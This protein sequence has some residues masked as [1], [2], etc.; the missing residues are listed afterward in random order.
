MKLSIIIPVYNEEQTIKE[1]ID[2]VRKVDLGEIEKEIVIVDDGSSDKSGQIIMSEIEEVDRGT[3]KTHLS[4]INLGKGAA[5]R[6]GM[7]I[8]TGD[9]FLI[10]DADLELDPNEYGKLL[11]PIVAG[12]TNVVY[13]SRFL[14]GKN[15]VPL[16]TWIANRF[17]TLLTNMLYGGKLTDMETSYKVLRREVVEGLRLRSVE[18]D[19]EPEITA[20]ILKKGEKIIELPI[21]YKPR[22]WDEGKK[23]GFKDGI[24]AIFTLFK[25]R[26]IR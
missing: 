12:H 19:F 10:Q 2:K 17:L 7:V 3:V 22:R 9:I 8:A 20:K 25:Y 26:F 6:F 11:E 14:D 5:V 24:D 15:N 4:I 23:I 16:K 13:G 18:F 21:S 1:V